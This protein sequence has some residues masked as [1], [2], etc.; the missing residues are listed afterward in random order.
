MAGGLIE[1][2]VAGHRRLQKPREGP[3]PACNGEAAG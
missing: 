2:T 3:R 1:P